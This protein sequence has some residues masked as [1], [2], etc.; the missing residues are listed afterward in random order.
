MRALVLAPVELDD[1]AAL[2]PQA[3]DRPRAD[4][5]VALGQLDAVADE[6][7]AEAALQAA[8]HLAVARRVLVQRGA[9]VGAARVPAAQRALDVGGAQVV[10]EL[11]FGERAQQRAAVVAGR[12]VQ[13]GA[14]D[15]GGGEA[16]VVGAVA[17]AQ[18]AR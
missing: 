12:E 6:Q 1:D 18:V 9:Q 3:V 13:Q 16:A 7:R 8:L 4:R 2:A 14:R 10:L 17:G 15:G 5:L 11:G